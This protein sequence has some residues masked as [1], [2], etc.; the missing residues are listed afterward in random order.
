[1]LLTRTP[2]SA[3]IIPLSDKLPAT[4]FMAASEMCQT[5]PDLFNVLDPVARG[6]VLAR[7]KRIV[8]RKDQPVFRQGER[9][10]GI[11]LIE[12]GLVRVFY[13]A[14]TGREITL[15]YWTAGNFC[16]G[17][18]VFGAG[19]HVWSG[20]AARDTA[21]IALSGRDLRTLV[22]RFPPLAIGI[23]ECL[24]FKGSCY[25]HLAQLLGT[26]SVTE[27]LVSVLHQMVRVYGRPV[28]GAVEIAMPF[29]HD[30]LASMVGA[31]RQWVS[32][33]L[34]RF[35][36]AGLLA[37]KRRRILI[38]DPPRLAAMAESPEEP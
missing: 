29:T 4:A 24:I 34:R 20:T 28:D 5:Q 21:V 26:R 2:N 1:M 6:V 11:F 7:G 12:S 25:S 35:A 15:A 16:G 8:F 33:T 10:D 38:L 36:K 18:E 37:L 31:T 23:I 13:T 3:P 27:R 17:P 14:P 22:D 19:D 30:D 32:M 9:H